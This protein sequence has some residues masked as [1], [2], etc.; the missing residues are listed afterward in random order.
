MTK[1][2]SMRKKKKGINDGYQPGGEE[3]GYQPK[4]GGKETA[5]HKPKKV[6]KKRKPPGNE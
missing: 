2:I 6:T 3:K 4:K 1:E 5:G